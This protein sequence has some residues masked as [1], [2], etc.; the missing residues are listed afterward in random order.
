MFGNPE[1]TPGGRA[2]KFFSSVRLD[3]RRKDALKEGEDIKG[4]I[5]EVKVVKNKVAPPFKK[6]KFDMMFG[7]GISKEGEVLELAEQAGVVVKSGA[8][9]SYGEM[10]IGQGRENSKAF[11][12][13][14]PDIFGEIVLK[15]KR[16]LGM[17]PLEETKK[18][19][20]T[21]AVEEKKKSVVKK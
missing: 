1:T 16:A 2:L 5:T 6:A 12:K 19:E 13:D 3:I 9:Y 8:W 4:Y 14:N 20:K 7:E 10:R 21:A 11:L 17:L 18:E 15:V